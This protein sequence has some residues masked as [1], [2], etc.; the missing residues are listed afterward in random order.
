MNDPAHRPGAAYPAARDSSRK[1]LADH[2]PLGLATVIFGALRDAAAYRR[3]YADGGPDFCSE[4]EEAR[5]E[6]GDPDTLCLDHA[7]DEGYAREYDAACRMLSG[8][9][10]VLSVL[11]QALPPAGWVTQWYWPAGAHGKLWNW[12]HGKGWWVG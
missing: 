1:F 8:P 3:E 6:A 12:F 9:C 10:L 7:E 5:R 2:P 4:C 11:W